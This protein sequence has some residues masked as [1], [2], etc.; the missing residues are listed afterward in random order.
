MDIV[1]FLTQSGVEFEGTVHEQAFTAQEVAA[2]EH[3]SG[4]IFAKT[5]IVKAGDA[6]CMLVLPASRHVDLSKVAE[7]VGAETALATEPEMKNLFQDCEIGA[8][9]PFGSHYDVKTFLDRSLSDV[10]QIVF[11]AGRHSRT[12]KMGRADYER[13]EEPTVADFA[14]R[15]A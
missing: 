10:D 14:I 1:E 3:V 11:R 15:E 7:L 13:L 8:E 6:Y 5:V 12:V 4:H 2:T 9:P